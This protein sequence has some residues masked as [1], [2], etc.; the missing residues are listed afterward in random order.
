[1]QSEQRKLIRPK[2]IRRAKLDR[3]DARIARDIKRAEEESREQKAKEE[4]GT[5]VGKGLGA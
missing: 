5:A 2:A 4:V 3:V 1:M